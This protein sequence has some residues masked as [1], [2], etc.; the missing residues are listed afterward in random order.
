[1]SNNVVFIGDKL[2]ANYM[3]FW[4]GKMEAADCHTVKNSIPKQNI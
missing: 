2:V 3:W 4:P 1:L